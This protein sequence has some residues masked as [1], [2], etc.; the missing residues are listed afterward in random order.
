MTET[1]IDRGQR[2]GRLTH[3]RSCAAPEFGPRFFGETVQG[4][5]V[6]SSKSPGGL[7][8]GGLVF[9]Q[10]NQV[11]SGVRNLEVRC[12]ESQAQQTVAEFGV[13]EQRAHV[14]AR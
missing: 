13:L 2:Q 11:I 3:E 14:R 1:R 5:K 12:A 9:F 7:E 6:S 4:E 8:D 10:G